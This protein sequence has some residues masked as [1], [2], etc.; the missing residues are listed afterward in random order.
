MKQPRPKISSIAEA[1][2]VAQSSS[3]TLVISIKHNKLQISDL[4]NHP[5]KGDRIVATAIDLKDLN[6]AG[7]SHDEAHIV[8]QSRDVVEVINREKRTQRLRINNGTGALGGYYSADFLGD[9][10]VLTVWEFGRARVWSIATGRFLD[11]GDFKTGCDGASWALRPTANNT[12]VAM[13]IHLAKDGAD[14]VICIRTEN[15]TLLTSIRLRTV[16]AQ[17]VSFSHDGRWFA[18]RD[19][20]GS[21]ERESVRFYSPEG[22]SY[23]TY[24]HGSHDRMQHLGVKTVTW[25]PAGDLVALSDFSGYV[26]LL[27]TRVFQPRTTISHTSALAYSTGEEAVWREGACVSNE[28]E[29]SLVKMCQ[30]V[31]TRSKPSTDPQELG[32]AQARFNSTGRYIATRDERYQSTIWIWTFPTA[33][34]HVLH[35][36]LIQYH[37]VRTMQWHPTIPHSLMFDC[38]EDIVYHYDV[39][40]PEKPPR[41]IN[42]APALRGTATYGWVTSTNSELV[43]RAATKRRY[44]LVYPDREWG[45]DEAD[46]EMSQTRPVQMGMPAERRDDESDDSLQE[47]LTGRKALSARDREDSHANLA[48][49]NGDSTAGMEDTFREK[50]QKMAIEEVEADPLDDSDIF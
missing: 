3:G 18:V 30:P 8:L 14:D 15:G 16:D 22:L 24:P 25:S 9:E 38:G 12:L 6:S 7:F 50:K 41:I 40:K 31:S 44:C 19:T 33:E 45:S 20:P 28:R 17:D 46:A 49:A 43:I 23:L 26:V 32:I 47:L 36:V 29:Y 21:I 11:L 37:H 10:H 34:S 27:D 5:P 42:V 2:P 35:A 48:D 13:F 4:V 39:S 1:R